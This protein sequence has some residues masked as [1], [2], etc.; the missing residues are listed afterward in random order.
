MGSLGSEE[1][2]VDALE[3]G[4]LVQG[5]RFPGT[6]PSA[7]AVWDQLLALYG[8]EISAQPPGVAVPVD[9]WLQRAAVLGGLRCW[10]SADGS[11]LDEWAQWWARASKESSR[12]EAPIMLTAWQQVH[13]GSWDQAHETLER[14][15]QDARQVA[16]ATATRALVR[17]AQGDVE[18]ARVASRKACRIARTDE[19]LCDEYF[20]N[21]VLA[22]VRRHTGALELSSRV[23]TA[24]ERVLPAPWRGLWAWESL[25]NGGRATAVPASSDTLAAAAG[26]LSQLLGDANNGLRAEVDHTWA[27][28]QQ[29]SVGAVHAGDIAAVGIAL[30]LTE[31]TGAMLPWARGVTDEVPGSVR[32]LCV[33]DLTEEGERAG[34]YVAASPQQGARRVVSAGAPL[35][36]FR[37]ADLPAEPRSADRAARALSALALARE[38]GLSDGSVFAAAYGFP[39]DKRR[40]NGVYRN[41]LSKVR[42]RLGDKGV[43][44]RLVDGYKLRLREPLVVPDPRCTIELRELLLRCMSKQMHGARSRDLARTLRVPLRTV[45]AILG[46]LVEEGACEMNKDG[47]KV[48]YRLEDTTFYEPSLTRLSA[49]RPD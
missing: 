19:R 36:L 11:G 7:N 1:Q 23:L 37:G 26:E 6:A 43:L 9:D 4:Q 45:Q 17:L 8:R 41:L 35:F 28:L 44:E 5:E 30:G 25:L 27:K 42:E 31:P 18:S 14:V 47:R 34:A 13:A 24:L 20:A 49:G 46:E 21:L 48:V 38:E 10:L 15:G 39:Y 22:R 40:N 32:G 2:W 33:P 3:R 16:F 12:R 29:C